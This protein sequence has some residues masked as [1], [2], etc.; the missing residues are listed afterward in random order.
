MDEGWK[1]LECGKRWLVRSWYGR[2]DCEHPIGDGSC[3]CVACGESKSVIGEMVVVVPGMV[4]WLGS[5]SVEACG[6]MVWLP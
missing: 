5:G 6:H 3:G 4:A 1:W 2:I